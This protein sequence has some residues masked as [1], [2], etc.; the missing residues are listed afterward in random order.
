MARSRCILGGMIV[1]TLGV[2]LIA[3]G[4]AMCYGCSNVLE[5]RKASDAPAEKSMRIALLWHLAHEPL[6]WLG[7]GVDIAGFGLQAVALGRGA[8][9]TVQPLLV[10]SLV[11]SLLLGARMGSHHLSRG[12]LLW[13]LVFVGALT[14]F[15]VAGDPSGGVDERS[16]RAWSGTLAV[17]AL[18]VSTCVAL[19]RRVRPAHRAAVLGCAAG[20]M[21]GVSSTLMKS[22]AFEVSHDGFG[23][24]THWQPYAMFAVVSIGFLMVQSAFQAGDLRAA[25]P[26]VELAEPVV[27]SILGLT[28]M[29]EHFSNVNVVSAGAL[30]AAV[31]LMVLSTLH[32]ARAAAT[33]A[34][35]SGAVPMSLG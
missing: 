20:V 29:G 8:L 17:I 34:P 10:M 1:Q 15:L 25:L 32:L 26:A 9:V 33:P 19:S 27:A 5:Q 6:W 7:I 30:L 4:A 14:L 16:F 31:A 28:L 11:F 18:V 2:S 35:S 13:V 23:L 22:F 21:F 24:V 3:L 12:D